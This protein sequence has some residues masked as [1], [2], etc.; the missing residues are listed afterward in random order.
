ML[1]CGSFLLPLNL[2]V[3]FLNEW[4]FGQIFLKNCIWFAKASFQY[5][6]AHEIEIWTNSEV[7]FVQSCFQNCTNLES[8]AIHTSANFNFGNDAF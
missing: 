7:S 2:V 3:Y 8:L 4:I 5:S 6:N 1:G